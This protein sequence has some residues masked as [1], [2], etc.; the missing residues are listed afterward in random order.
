MIALNEYSSAPDELP[1]VD[2]HV[3]PIPTRSAVYSPKPLA[4]GTGM[5]ESLWGY[6]VRLADAH[7]VRFHD[8]FW[9]VVAPIAKIERTQ[10]CK[11]AI[12]PLKGERA[13]RIV[14]AVES[15]TMRAGLV[16]TTLMRSEKYSCVLAPTKEHRE[17]CPNCL[18][19]DD[20]PYDRLVWNLKDYSHCSLHRTKL[21]DRCPTCQR[22]QKFGAVG[23]SIGHCAYCGGSLAAI[24]GGTLLMPFDYKMW[25]A[26][27]A[28]GFLAQMDKQHIS[29]NVT[30]HNLAATMVV[31]GGLKS[32][33]RLLRVSP[34]TLRACERGNSRMKLDLALRWAWVTNLSIGDLMCRNVEMTEIKLRTGQKDWRPRTRHLSQ[35]VS[36]AA[37]LEALNAFLASQPYA[38]PTKKILIRQVGGYPEHP[39]NNAQVVLSVLEE[40]K[41]SRKRLR[42]KQRV[43]AIVCRVYRAFILA[44]RSGRPLNTRNLCRQLGRG[45]DMASPLAQQYFTVLKQQY[46]RGQIMP[47]PKKRVP[48]DV[49]EFW[50]HHGLT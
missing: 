32:L 16:R 38:I 44:E 2:L 45:G 46:T 34:A 24:K 30:A 47:D 23:G 14:A 7:A 6:L 15:V 12:V 8:L 35:P 42:Y 9:A 25:V 40:S 43:W 28:A 37:Y 27:E 10:S 29:Q 21:V 11:V 18:A 19:S 22:S 36:A 33:S 3:V 20:E 26:R 4:I 13:A 50:A 41:R 39:A 49:R 31:C 1:D 48:L 17:W 5:V